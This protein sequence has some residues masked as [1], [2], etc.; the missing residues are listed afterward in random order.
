[1]RVCRLAIAV[2]VQRPSLL[3]Q[4]HLGSADE[5]KER[6][7]KNKKREKRTGEEGKKEKIQRKKEKG[8]KNK[9][10][11]RSG[12]PSQYLILCTANHLLELDLSYDYV[13]EARATQN[14]EPWRN[15]DEDAD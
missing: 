2:E 1:R 3:G 4:N 6:R 15:E 8:R 9:R 12:S 14:F 13:V 11:K 10:K 7:R 5:E